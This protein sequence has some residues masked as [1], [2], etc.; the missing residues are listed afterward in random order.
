MTRFEVQRQALQL[1][2]QERFELAEELWASIENP[3]ALAGLS[4][5][6]WQKDLLDERLEESRNDPGKP[7]SEVKAE[8]WATDS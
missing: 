1:P 6:Q 3:D 4:L 5:A 7:W 2:E 8:I